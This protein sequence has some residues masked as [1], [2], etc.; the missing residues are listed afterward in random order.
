MQFLASYILSSRR[1]AVGVV[2]ALLALSLLLP[3][4]ALLSAAAVALV[5]LRQG[6]REGAQVMGWS[7]ALAAVLGGFSLGNPWLFV[8]YAG[9]MWLPS[10]LTAGVLRARIDLALAL[11]SGVWLVAAAVFAVYVGLDAPAALWQD[12]LERMLTPV[13]ESPPPGITTEDI[14]ARMDDMAHY[15]T[16]M[17]AA[18]GFLGMALSLCLARGWQALLFNPGGF[19]REYCAL[20]GRTPLAYLSLALLLSLWGSDAATAEWSGNL[21]LPMATYYV[22]V[23]AALLHAYCSRFAVSRWLLVALYGLVLTIPHVLLPVALL[24]FS[25]VWANWRRR[26]DA[27]A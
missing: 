18:G 7:A 14:R 23:G 19:M 2:A 6:L 10:A 16:G 27:T 9:V 26:I 15:M 22:V 5:I 8:I 11:E 24:G 12:N 1:A 17:A 25:D 21:L 3:P 20:R 13:L 4:I